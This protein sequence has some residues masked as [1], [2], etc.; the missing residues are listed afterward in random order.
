[1]S[2]R[3]EKE[4]ANDIKEAAEGMETYRRNMKL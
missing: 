3:G 4:V 1:M 2:K